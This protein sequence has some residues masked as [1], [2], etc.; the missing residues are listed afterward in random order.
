MKLK[1]PK[2]ADILRQFERTGGYVDDEGVD[3]NNP[4]PSVKVQR[5]RPK[6]RK[7]T[8]TYELANDKRS[9]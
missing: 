7:N 5:V 1:S 9:L 2:K 3:L 6:K 4:T 8:L